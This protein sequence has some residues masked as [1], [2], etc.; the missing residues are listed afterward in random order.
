MIAILVEARRAFAGVALIL[1]GRQDFHGFFDVSASGFLRS[2]WAAAIALPAFI[3]LIAADNHA[4]AAAGRAT[5]TNPWAIG[6]R[7]LVLWLYF[8]VFAALVARLLDRRPAFAPWVV[9]HNW[10]AA[11][12]LYANAFIAMLAVARA[13]SGPLVSVAGMLLIFL[14]VYAH[15]RVAHAALGPPWALAIGAACAQILA[16]LVLQVAIWRVFA[17]P[18]G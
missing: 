18:A 7:Y 5:L 10:T 15:V 1:R 3:F 6:L 2:F 13:L 16:S 14:T 12:L 11:A 9:A 8:P 4:L 17:A